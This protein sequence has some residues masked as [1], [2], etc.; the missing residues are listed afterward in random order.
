MGCA[1]CSL[2]NAC[3]HIPGP[4]CPFLFYVV[5]MVLIAIPAYFLWIGKDALNIG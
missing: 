1:R 3:K 4:I 2:R 5:L